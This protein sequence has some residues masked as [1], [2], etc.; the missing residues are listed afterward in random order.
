MKIEKTELA[1]KINMVKSIVPKK[2]PYEA[3]QG[4]L[5]EGNYLIANNMETAAKVKIEATTDTPFIIPSKAFD[6]INSLPNGEVE[7]KPGKDSIIIEVGNIKN[8][9][10]AHSE[11]LFQRPNIEKT[12]AA[13]SF[14]ISSE[15]FLRSVKRVAFAVADNSA[16]GTMNALC[17]RA[18]EGKLNYI[19]LDGHMIAWDKM[20]YDGEF[21]L[22]IPKNT[23]DKLL[24]IGLNGELRIEHSD[25][26][27]LFITE[28]CEVSTRLVNGEYFD[29]KKMMMD[30]TL[31]TS[32]SRPRMLE[33]LNRA[34]MCCMGEKSPVKMNFT[35]NDVSITTAVATAN[36]DEEIPLLKNME[37]PL[38]IGFDSKLLIDCLRAFDNEEVSLDFTSA[39]APLL[40]HAEDTEFLTLLLP[41]KLRGAA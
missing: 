34:R 37:S 38:T 30:G 32:V 18:K 40:I 21:E 29:V 17:L 13:Q 24:S 8:K 26:G 39:K 15:S 11:D 5:V 4:V 9:F 31:H 20:D 36:Y 7:I 1:G 10:A 2:T 33:A 3:I 12:D 22:L 28:E 23:I 16:N 27:A 14:E 19:G 6:L 35:E 25:T 41:V